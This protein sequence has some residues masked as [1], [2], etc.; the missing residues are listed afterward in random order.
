MSLTIVV[1][2]DE[3]NVSLG[4]IPTSV[5]AVTGDTSYP[6]SGYTA[7]LGFTAANLNCGRGI[8]GVALLGSNTAALGYV[9]WYNSTTGNLQILVS[10]GAGVALEE[11]PGN[12][13]VST[14]T[15][16]LFVIGQR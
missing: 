9:P 1:Q 10:A 2:P 16:L 3:G 5:V 12:P 7:A 14:F 11:V 13:N 4:P 6:T 8:I 15:W